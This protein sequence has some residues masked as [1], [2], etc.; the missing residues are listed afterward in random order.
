M[1]ESTYEASSS[2]LISKASLR[3]NSAPSI[4]DACITFNSSVT[5]PTPSPTTTAARTHQHR[6]NAAQEQRT[7]H[8]SC[9]RL[10]SHISSTIGLCTDLNKGN[11][12]KYPMYYPQSTQSTKKII[13]S[14]T[15]DS[16]AILEAARHTTFQPNLFTTDLNILGL[17][18]KMG[19]TSTDLNTLETQSITNLLSDRLN[20][21]LRY[22]EKL[23]SRVADTSSKVLVTGDLNSG[24]STFVNALLKRDIL[25]ADQQ[26]CT[27]IFCEVLD[28]MLNDGLEEV[29]AIPCVEKY[30]RLDPDTYHVIEM[31][32][33]YKV[34]TEDF[35]QYKMLKIYAN[36]ARNSQESLLHNGVVDIAL[37]DSPGLNTDSVKT[38]A[39][40][41]R[42]EEIDVVVFVVSAENHFTLSG[43]EFLWNA[44][45]EKTHIFIVVNR[46]DSIKDK[47][48]CKRLILE[49]IRQ[50]SPATY[51]DADD[52][53][54][55][56]SAGNVDLE[57]GSRKLDAPDFARLE[58]RLRAFVLE[59]RTK[60]KLLPAKNYLVN[61]L[62]DINVLSLANKTKS[63]EDHARATQE[64]EQDLPAYEHLL[65][66]RDRMLRQVEKV[67]ENTVSSIQRHANNKLNQ[68]VE[69]IGSAIHTIEYPGILLVWQY[70]QDIADSMCQKL[71]KDIKQEESHARREASGCLERIHEMGTEHLG[72]YPIMADVNK[73]CVK[74][75]ELTITVE[76]TDFFDLVLDDKLSG[77]ALSVGAATMVGG[78]MLGFKDA[79]SSL[80]SVSNII[81]SPNVRR[82]VV[83]V[84]GIASVGFLVYVVSDMRHA[85][86]RKLLKK[87]KNAVRETGYIE[88][89]SH[90]IAR[91][92]RKILRVE[93][94]EIQNRIQKAIEDK[95]YKRDETQAFA[96]SSRETAE[97]FASILEKSELLLEKVKMVVTDTKESFA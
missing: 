57:P 50:L 25:P 39:V 35:E 5:S 68:A 62:L 10:I 73:L 81:E 51:A 42:Q 72:Q 61:L 45:N 88:I 53:V 69:N 16:S 37:I 54:H 52:L 67:A 17:D 4:D 46:F 3:R 82:W 64:L 60:S 80:W 77:A 27:S 74:P 43:K 75:K 92:S 21:S 2:L 6:L 15:M 96:E 31:R 7:Y 13:R 85:V 18:L 94:W 34:I 70:A 28:A 56:V 44:A 78:R 48:R 40:F 83:P 14:Q 49:Q 86:E 33:L 24:K 87:F 93:G 84:V 38:T 63:T 36:D 26:P 97:F 89:Q 79:V 95:E 30:N 71:L 8:D 22:L 20:T 91:E 11:K 23:Q 41:A 65:R 66:I 29:H 32:H 1:S 47:D 9:Q 59:N 55:F 19:H 58:Q 76:A 12:G 90:R